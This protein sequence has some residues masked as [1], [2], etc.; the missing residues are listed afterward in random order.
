M[1]RKKYIALMKWYFEKN[2]DFEDLAEAYPLAA[3]WVD[4]YIATYGS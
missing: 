3:K 1:H 4:K 2:I